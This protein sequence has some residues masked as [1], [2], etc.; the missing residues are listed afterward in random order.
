MHHAKPTRWQTLAN[1]PEF[2]ALLRSRRRFVV[3]A[4]VF[5]VA[6]Y[7]ALPISVG[8]LPH[9][10]SR[11]VLG[12]LTLAYCFALSQFVTAWILLALYLRR[13]RGF[14]VRAARI[15]RRETRDIIDARP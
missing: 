3:P 5:F 13:A 9:A 11:P 14:D 4:T 8:F 2:R 7:L 15:R 6:Y 12:P 10:M 1:Q